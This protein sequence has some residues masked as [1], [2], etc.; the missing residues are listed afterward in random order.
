[1]GF[2]EVGQIGNGK[3]A[4]VYRWRK[5]AIAIAAS[6]G[7]PEVLTA[8]EVKS[9]SSIDR[10]LVVFHSPTGMAETGLPIRRS[11]KMKA[12]GAW[13]HW[14]DFKERRPDFLCGPDWVAE[15]EG[16]ETLVLVEGA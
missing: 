9:P 14:P 7:N 4:S 5:V 16:F 8:S 2:G 10:F 6:A 12:V 13:E 11:E 15:G 3:S 1:M